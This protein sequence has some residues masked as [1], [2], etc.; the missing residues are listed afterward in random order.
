[1]NIDQI[2]KWISYDMLIGS[3]TAN[4]KN[5]KT[6]N[7]IEKKYQIYEPINFFKKNFNVHPIFFSY[8]FGLYDSETVEIVKLFYKFAFTTKRGRYNTLKFNNLE[9]PR[10]PINKKDSIFKFFLKTQ[11]FYEDIK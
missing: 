6:L 10:I 4:H 9:I 1:M 3:H 8:P 2:H 7:K 11:T 5:L